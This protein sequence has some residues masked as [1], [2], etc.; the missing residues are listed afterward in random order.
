[1]NTNGFIGIFAFA[2]L[3]LI[4]RAAFSWLKNLSYE[5]AG[6]TVRSVEKYYD[7]V[8]RKKIPYEKE[9]TWLSRISSKLVLTKALY[10]SYYFFTPYCLNLAGIALSAVNIFVPAL[11]DI[12]NKSAMCMLALCLFSA[13]CSGLLFNPLKH[14]IKKSNPKKK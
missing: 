5:A 7:E 8:K 11:N 1:M 12:M 6:Q 13:L 4:S 2:V 3:Y 9:L 14:L 10:I